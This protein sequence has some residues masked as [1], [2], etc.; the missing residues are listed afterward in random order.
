LYTI[1]ELNKLYKKFSKDVLRGLFLLGYEE[2]EVS[3]ILKKIF[4][5]FLENG[6][7]RYSEERALLILY[8]RLEKLD[9]EYL[10]ALVRVLFYC[11]KLSEEKI[12]DNLDLPLSLVSE[13]I[14]RNPSTIECK[15]L[16]VSNKLL[17][18]IFEDIRD[19][20]VK[21]LIK[22]KKGYRLY[23]AIL[24]SV[25]VGVILAI[26]WFSGL[27]NRIETNLK[28]VGDYYSAG[29][30]LWIGGDYI[31]FVASSRILF[32]ENTPYR[33]KF[34]LEEGKIL[35]CLKNTKIKVKAPYIELNFLPVSKKSCNILSIEKKPDRYIIKYGNSSYIIRKKIYITFQAY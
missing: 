29:Y 27:K 17:N 8:N 34:S 2:D 15:R 1:L 23:P 10:Y 13:V 31:G 25:V 18:K 3:D 9:K 22:E 12:A 4:F 32:Y 21:V 14:N 5:W 6:Y 35:V 20:Y 30:K 33:I 24:F 19:F 16:R 26:L 7:Y 28:A 11:R